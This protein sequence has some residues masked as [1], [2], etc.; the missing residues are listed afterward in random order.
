MTH[1][2]ASKPDGQ[3]DQTASRT[4]SMIRQTYFKMQAA[5]LLK[6]ADITT[7]AETAA[8]LKAKAAELEARAA[9]VRA[10]P[11]PPHPPSEGGM[12]NQGRACPP[13]LEPRSL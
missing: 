5:T 4:A 9:A 11:D 1:E 3:H 7:N 6:L 12:A 10:L 13:N 8:A 2:M